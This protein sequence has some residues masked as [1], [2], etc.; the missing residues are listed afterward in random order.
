[1]PFLA[2]A[3]GIGFGQLVVA[4]PALKTIQQSPS[5]SAWPTS[6]QRGL[7]A[8]IHPPAPGAWSP[9]ERLSAAITNLATMVKRLE[10]MSH[11]LQAAPLRDIGISY[12]V[13]YRTTPTTITYRFSAVNEAQVKQEQYAAYVRQR[14]AERQATLQAGR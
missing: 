5:W 9:P 4:T 6:W 3:G 12:G 2:G 7:G 1:M 10:Q 11:A 13:D 14:E 8:S